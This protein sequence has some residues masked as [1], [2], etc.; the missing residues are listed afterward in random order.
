ME[1]VPNLVCVVHFFCVCRKSSV[2]MCNRLLSGNFILFFFPLL[3]CTCSTIE[4]CTWAP[5]V[6]SCQEFWKGV[7]SQRKKNCK[8]SLR[9]RN[10]CSFG[11]LVLFW[12]MCFSVGVKGCARVYGHAKVKS[13]LYAFYFNCINVACFL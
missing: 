6:T 2:V 11:L 10:V 12:Q 4:H 1:S 5:Y 7:F 13:A 8:Y 3:F 9:C